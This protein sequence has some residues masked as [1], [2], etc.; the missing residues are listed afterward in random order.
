MNDDAVTLEVG[1]REVVVTHPGKLLI[2]TARVRKIDLVQYYVALADGAL[3]GAGGRPCVLVRHPNGL[4]APYFFQKR[5]PEPRPGWVEVAQL[6][7]P[8]GR[9]A[10]EVVPRH[11]SDLAWMANL[12]C[13]ELH[14]HSVRPDDLE[15]PDEL[16][17]DLD[18]VPGVEWPQIVHVAGVA[19]AVLG[20]AGLVGWPKTSG[21]RGIHVLVRIERRWNHDA[22]RR[23]ALAFAREV[24]RRAPGLATSAWH[25]EQ[26]EGVFVDY[27]QNAR[28]RTVCSAWS[29]RARPD[30]RVSTPVDWRE[31]ERCDP[32]AFTLWTIPARWRKRGDPHAA[33]DEHA[34]VLDTLLEWSARDEGAGDGDAPT[35]FRSRPAQGPLIEAAR[36]AEEAAVQPA[37]D[38][39]KKAHPEAAARLA[40]RDVLVDRMRGRSSLSYRVRINLAR[41]PERLRPA[42]APAR[43]AHAPKTRASS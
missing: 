8:S 17:I 3:R 28:D 33:M 41:V 14:P 32:A 34:G 20:D 39:W 13:L 10:Q 4:G 26:R 38:A 25:K 7:Y 12:A 29:V 11:A 27:N 43:K 1:G 35:R 15:H 36:V 2:P 6:H 19:R 9:T 30:A 21:S 18:P 23:A 40:P 5:A 31:L 24:E 16:R 37:I 42:P 22:V